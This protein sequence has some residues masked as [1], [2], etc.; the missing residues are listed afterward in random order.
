MLQRASPGGD[1]LTPFSSFKTPGRYCCR[2]VLYTHSYECILSDLFSFGELDVL[3]APRAQN[4]DNKKTNQKN[5]Q[6]TKNSIG[7]MACGIHNSIGM[8]VCHHRYS[9]PQHGM[10][11]GIIGG[12]KQLRCYSYLCSYKYVLKYVLRSTKIC[13]SKYYVSNVAGMGCSFQ[14]TNPERLTEREYTT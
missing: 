1:A 11:H 4:R 12:G 2:Q 14:Q 5:K 7:T 8:I 6:T 10:A 3:F 13:T 9:Y